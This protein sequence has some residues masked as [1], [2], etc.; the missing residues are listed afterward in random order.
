MHQKNRSYEG[1]FL[2][3]TEA[4]AKSEAETTERARAWAEAKAREKVD[5]SRISSEAREKVGSETEAT[6]RVK[7]KAIK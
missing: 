1:E 6:T 3:L 5:I 4:R 2:L 7:E